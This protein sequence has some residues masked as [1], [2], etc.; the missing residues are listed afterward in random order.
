MEYAYRT[1]LISGIRRQTNRV[2]DWPLGRG[3]A[4]FTFAWAIRKREKCFILTSCSLLRSYSVRG[5]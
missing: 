5:T 2:K 1:V 4:I 3:I